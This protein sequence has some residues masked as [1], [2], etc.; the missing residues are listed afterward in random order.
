MDFQYRVSIRGQITEIVNLENATLENLTSAT[1][2]LENIFEDLEVFFAKNGFS[3]SLK[4]V[5]E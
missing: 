2:Q 1:F 4:E 3:C 5:K